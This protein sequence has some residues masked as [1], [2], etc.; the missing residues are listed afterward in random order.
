MIVK[1]KDGD[2]V[3]FLDN[4]LKDGSYGEKIIRTIL[5]YISNECGKHQCIISEDY[6]L[7]IFK[8]LYKLNVNRGFTKTQKYYS[9]ALVN[10]EY[11]LITF[12]RTIFN[13]I[14]NTK[15]YENK[16]F[17]VNIKMSSGFPNY[18]D[19]YF[20]ESDNEEI[21]K[22]FLKAKTIYI[23]DIVDNMKWTKDK[24]YKILIEVFKSYDIKSDTIKS[25]TLKQRE[26]K[27][28]RVLSQNIC[29]VFELKNFSKG[30]SEKQI[31]DVI[32]EIGS[33]FG[34]NVELNK[35]I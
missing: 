19:S 8:E 22:E 24:N 30:M 35:L 18:E 31:E 17:N 15:N 26:L 5:Y 29:D 27:L 25:I 20:C 21:S 32:K 12:S 34:Y 28:K 10:D 14:E 3:R 7:P 33:T 16:I 2:K 23:E 11:K 4:I 13:M 6:K 1:L 9:Y